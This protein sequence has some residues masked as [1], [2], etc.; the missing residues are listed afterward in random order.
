MDE[1]H[2]V[3][4]RDVLSERSQEIDNTILS[5]YARGA[6]NEEAAEEVR[7]YAQGA[8]GLTPEACTPGSEFDSTCSTVFEEHAA[9]LEQSG[10]LKPGAGDSRVVQRQDFDGAYQIGAAT[11]GSGPRGAGKSGETGLP[12]QW[13][14]QGQATNKQGTDYF[15]DGQETE[16]EPGLDHLRHQEDA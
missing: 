14:R 8:L 1:Q 15:R 5:A 11:G 4:W 7:N 12:D 13:G 16:P 2:P 9:R 6:S 3:R 10:L